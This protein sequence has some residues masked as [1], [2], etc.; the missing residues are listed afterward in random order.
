MNIT[1]KTTGGL[2]YFAHPYTRK[3]AEGR[4]VR[5]AEEANFNLCNMRA[6]ELIRRGFNIYSPISHTHPIHRA[7]PALLAR[8]EHEMWY[9]LDNEF[10]DS[11]KWQGIILPPEWETSSGCKAE[12]ERIRVLGGMVKLYSTILVAYPILRK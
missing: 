10:I 9:Q 2:W 7:C 11:T 8:H 6:G 5:E 12:K 1:G 4:F 3:D